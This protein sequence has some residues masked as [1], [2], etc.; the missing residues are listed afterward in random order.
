MS[1]SRA[2]A[3]GDARRVDLDADDLGVRPHPAQPVVELD[4][5]DGGGAVAEVDDDRRDQRP[6][7]SPRGWAR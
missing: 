3:R 1:M 4:R 2:F 7:Q 6:T 5:G